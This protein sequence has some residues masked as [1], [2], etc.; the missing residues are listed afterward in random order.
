MTTLVTGASGFVGSAVMRLLLDKGHQVRVL[1]REQA[2]LDNIKDYNVEIVIGDLNDIDSLRQATQGCR[3]LFHVAADYRLWVPDHSAMYQTNVN[4]TENLLRCAHQ[5]EVEKIVYTS[6][7]ATLGLHRDGSSADEETPVNLAAMIGHYKRS[8]FLAEQ[9][10]QRLYQQEQ[11]PVTIV[12]PS[13][14]IGP[15]DIKPT[16]TGKMILDA[17]RGRIPAYVDTGLNVVHVDD[18]AMGHYLA[19]EHGKIG[20]R[21]I[22]GG[23]NMSLKVILEFI[24]K[25]EH[26]P[27]PRIALP[28]NAILPIAY[29]LEIWARLMGGTPRATVDEIRMAKKKM[30]FCSNKAQQVLGYQPRRGQE[31]II[32][33]LEWFKEH[34][35]P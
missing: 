7:T 23:D 22:L 10:V 16:P 27:P 3:Y 8:K 5:S 32:A 35:Y 28:H 11:V 17:L 25:H 31:G 14:P 26:L 1:V 6:S 33:A 30:Y 24:A 20:D 21:Y 4:G 34:N 19:L 15:N 18:V 13:T 2:R 9:A 29:L 12:N